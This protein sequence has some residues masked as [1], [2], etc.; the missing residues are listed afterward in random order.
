MF[1]VFWLCLL[2]VLLVHLPA[3]AQG[4]NEPIRFGPAESWVEIID[5]PAEPYRLPAGAQ[6]D[7]HGMDVLSVQQRYTAQS[8]ETYHRFR[9][10]FQSTQAVLSNDSFY[11]LIDPAYQHVV[12]HHVDVYR[13]DEVIKY[14]PETQFQSS[15]LEPDRARGVYENRQLLAYFMPD[16]RAGDTLDIA[17]TIHGRPPEI[18]KHFAATLDLHYALPAKHMLHRIL[19]PDGVNAT[20]RAEGGAQDPRTQTQSGLTEYRWEQRDTI[21]PKTIDGAPLWYA[22]APRAHLTSFQTWEEVGALLAPFYALP[23]QRADYSVARAAS[24]ILASHDTDKTQAR[25]A[26]EYVQR[27]FRHM[28]SSPTVSGYAPRKVNAILQTGFG[29]SKD[30][31]LVLR[32][33]L[34]QLDIEA[35]PVFVNTALRGD[36]RRFAPRHDVFNHVVLRVSIGGEDYFVDPARDV[37]LGTLDTLAQPDFALGLDIASP[38]RGLIALN[39][40]AAEWDRVT[41][42]TFTIEEGSPDIAF[43]V[44]TVSYGALA[45]LLNGVFKSQGAAPFEKDYLAYFADQYSNLEQDGYLSVSVDEEDARFRITAR[46]RIRDAWAPDKTGTR[47]TFEALPLML[48]EELPPIVTGARQHPY[49]LAHPLRAKDVLFL[50]LADDW[51]I[52]P[53]RR[54][55]QTGSFSYQH[56]ESF[57]NGVLRSAYAYRSKRGHIPVD[58]LEETMAVINAI[59]DDI[60]TSLERPTAAAMALEKVAQDNQTF[61]Q[62]LQRLGALADDNIEIVALLVGAV[63]TG[64]FAVL[65]IALCLQ[66]AAKDLPW[67]DEAIFYPVSMPIFLLLSIATL[68]LY[69]FYWAL[70]NWQWLKTVQGQKIWPAARALFLPVTNVMLLQAIGQQAAHDRSHWSVGVSILLAASYLGTWA[71][72]VLLPDQWSIAAVILGV[73][74][75][76]IPAARIAKLNAHRPHIIQRYSRFGWEKV[77]AVTIGLFLWAITV[78]GFLL[79]DA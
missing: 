33:L 64:L 40:P 19:V 53:R 48:Y 42:T 6:I 2:S 13:G 3:H 68:G 75:L 15:R 36:V 69:A 78:I 49:A 58:R 8:T 59:Y 52:K 14:F 45:D 30:L 74:V 24:D 67:R 23:D 41:N 72:Q 50:Q 7:A 77:L 43:A 31:V 63:L 22:S 44:T 18:G 71:G 79:P 57:E 70:K 65:S 16:L 38:S 60:G 5:P 9:S 47:E 1:R 66:A 20:V 54:S 76:A 73:F 39:P 61:G 21:P 34:A 4:D 25:A 29:D 46:Y 56:Q 11:I 32:A 35:A 10:T 12:V 37:Q 55:Q 27:T 62:K 17:Y 28:Q 51:D 26:L